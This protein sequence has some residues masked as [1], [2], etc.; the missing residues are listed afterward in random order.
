MHF[1]IDNKGGTMF[2]LLTE[3]NLITPELLFIWKKV[4]WTPLIDNQLTMVWS[5][6]CNKGN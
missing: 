3:T 5:K 1:V 6:N 2:Q 4:G